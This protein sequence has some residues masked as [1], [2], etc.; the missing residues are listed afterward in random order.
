MLEKVAVP[1]SVIGLN[2]TVTPL[3]IPEADRVTLPVKPY[4][5]LRLTKL[6]TDVPTPTAVVPDEL[7]VKVGT[8]T[9][10]FK[11]V[12]CVNDPDVPVIVS[13]YCPAVAEF[14]AYRKSELLEVVGFV[15]QSAVTPAGNPET[16]NT[17]LPVK[18]YS[19]VT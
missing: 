19:S 18:P 14:V 9:V 3:G 15:A 16:D 17:T 10:N 12:V 5:R 6:L 8:A 2:D 1:V 7:I 13:G 4:K 11:V